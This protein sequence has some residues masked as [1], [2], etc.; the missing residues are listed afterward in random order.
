M[1]AGDDDEVLETGAE[2]EGTEGQD[3]GGGQSEADLPA[4]QPDQE[5][6]DGEQ[7]VVAETRPARGEARIQRLANEA[8][9]ARE[10]A[11]AARREAE[12]L[13]RQQW[14]RE[15]QQTEAQQREMLA[16]MS[17][18]ERAEYRIKQMEQRMEGTLRQQQM[19]TA[20]QL[21][22]A[23][24]DANARV[25]PTYARHADEIERQF[26]E[27]LRLGRPVERQILLERHI[28]KLALQ[29]AGK[30]AGQRRQAASRVASQRVPASSGKGD[31]ASDR[32]RAGD[33]AE[34]RL[35]DVYI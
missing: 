5:A 14:Q 32:G 33:T 9:A 35:R 11:A 19:S 30:A 13:R 18:D 20:A 29:G 17:A 23:S 22:K 15:S 25:N 28:G 34:S 12:D 24:Y 3:I 10:E 21:D 7:E 1:S 2:G 16:L 4:E 6:D 8:K 26:Q 27:Q 31:A